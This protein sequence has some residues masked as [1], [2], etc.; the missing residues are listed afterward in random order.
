MFLIVCV[1]RRQVLFAA[2]RAVLSCMC[3]VDGAGNRYCVQPAWQCSRVC[4]RVD[5]AGEGYLPRLVTSA[6]SWYG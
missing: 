6:K 3:R 5:G 1:G 2:G 4:V